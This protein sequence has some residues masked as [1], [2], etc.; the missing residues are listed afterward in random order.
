EGKLK[1]IDFVGI[2]IVIATLIILLT[3]IIRIY[4]KKSYNKANVFVS[5]DPIISNNQD[6]LEYEK[7]VSYTLSYIDK[8]YFEKSFT[9]GVV[10]PWGNGK[11]SFIALVEEKLKKE[12]LKDTIYLKFLPYLNHSEKDIISEFFKQL[13]FEIKKYSGKLSNEFL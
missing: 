7:R 9:V 5:D 1:Y 12:P 10:G 6:K 4:R 11:S 3:E 8:A 13:S 2:L